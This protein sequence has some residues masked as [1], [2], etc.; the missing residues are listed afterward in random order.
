MSF[1]VKKHSKEEFYPTYC[2]WSEVHG[3]PIMN[4]EVLPQNC[5]V[6]YIDDI[7]IYAMWYWFTDAKV[8]VL[9]FMMS[10]KTVN[11]K[12]RIG[13]KQA[14]IK[15]II[16]YAKSKNQ[17]LLYCPTTSESVIEVIK[18]FGFSQGDKDSSQY[19]LQLK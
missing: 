15:R 1:I 18:E 3:F 7:P 16:E 6:T 17:L 8:S 19:F 10:D 13:G 9:G 2:K 5:F 11:Y 14:L 4:S 12:L